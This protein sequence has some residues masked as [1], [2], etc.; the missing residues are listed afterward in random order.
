MQQV[1]YC[2]VRFDRVAQM[3]VC[4][5]AVNIAPAFLRDRH[6]PDRLQITQ[7]GDNS[8]FSNANLSRN[9]TQSNAWR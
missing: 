8:P 9:L 2:P 4:I 6:N 5:D 3:N 1:S 7:Y